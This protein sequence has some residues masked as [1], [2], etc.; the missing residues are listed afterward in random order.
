MLI[1]H[2]AILCNQNV[3]ILI[4][5]MEHLNGNIQLQRE[6]TYNMQI[7]SEPFFMIK[8]KYFNREKSNRLKNFILRMEWQAAFT[9]QLLLFR[10]R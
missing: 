6:G 2:R 1:M 9:W 5:L 3:N 10:Y 7:E 4:E 8:E